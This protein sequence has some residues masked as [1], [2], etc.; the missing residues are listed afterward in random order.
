[1]FKDNLVKKLN[2]FKKNQLIY[3]EKKI[4]IKIQEIHHNARSEFKTEQKKKLTN[5]E[6]E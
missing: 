6:E 1:M 5:E 4:L 2:K 3:G